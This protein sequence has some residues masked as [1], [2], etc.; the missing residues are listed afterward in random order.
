MN[1][2]P[3]GELPEGHWDEVVTNSPDGWPFALSIWRRVILGVSEWQLEDHSFALYDRGQLSAVVP[4]Q[5]DRRNGAL[6]ITGWGGCGPIIAGH[7]SGRRRELVRNT[8]VRAID[9]AATKLRA[10]AVQLTVP[11][12]TASSIENIRGVNPFCFC[13]LDDRSGISQ[14][15]DLSS[16]EVTLWRGL[17]ETARQTVR[18]AE[19]SGI[20]IVQANWPKMLDRYYQIHQENYL[21]TGVIP[22][23]KSYFSGIAHE[24]AAAGY[25]VLWVAVNE[26][27]SVIACHNDMHFGAGAWYHT[28]CSTD[29]ALATG[30]NYL[31]FWKSML[32]AKAAGRRWYDCGEIFPA[33]SDKKLKGLTLFKT[34]FGGAPHRFL[35][36][37]KEYATAHNV[38]RTAQ[39]SPRMLLAGCMRRLG[40]L[41]RRR[42]LAV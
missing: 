1:A 31:L 19:K 15:I 16:D 6:G 2:V 24:T 41:P 23:P 10:T 30:A 11:P 26:M 33:S 12:V 37:G 27:G 13:G 17:S 3:Y 9:E 20:S 14:V 8:A 36:A 29:A 40:N 5:L 28:G 42:G 22:H 39:I 35:K 32:G 21:R 7:V 25:S 34:R 18:K 4:L 38:A